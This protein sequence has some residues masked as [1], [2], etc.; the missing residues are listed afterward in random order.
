[1]TNTKRE[2]IANADAHLNNAPS[3]IFRS[4]DAENIF[5]GRLAEDLEEHFGRCPHCGDY[6][7]YC[8]CDGGIAR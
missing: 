5:F 3:G 7:T 8:E 4:K 2:A 6:Y 1:M